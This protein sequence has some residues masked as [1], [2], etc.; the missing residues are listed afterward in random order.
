MSS[1]T[2]CRPLRSRR[3]KGNILVLSALLLVLM[4]AMAAFAVDLGYLCIARGELQRSADAAA[5]AACW[6][7]VNTGGPSGYS[8]YTALSD[9]A[10]A[11]AAQYATLNPI[12]SQGPA[13][14]S[15]DVEVGYIADPRDP[16]SPFL[17]N[18]ALP[19]NAVH[20]R[21]L[22]TADQ[23]GQLPL[24]FGRVLGIDKVN[25]QAD[26]TAAVMN[27]FSGFQAP[28]DGT[29]L[30]LLPFALDQETWDGLMNGVGT[31]NYSYNSATGEV[32]SGSDGILEV[33]LYPQ[34]TG[35]PG[36]RGTVDFGSSNNSTADISRQITSGVNASDMA[37]MG[38][39]VE[40]DSTGKLY[41]N[42]DTGISAGV[43][44]DLAS[45]KGLARIIPV[46]SSVSGPGNNATY[47]IVK[48]V[49]VRVTHVKLT[50]SMSSK[51]VIIQP[52]I[53]KTKGGIPSPGGTTSTF[54]YS[55]V[56]IVR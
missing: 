7:L 50:G 3:R 56:W 25:G 22:K 14:G 46:F 9:S 54:V 52:A 28:S 42:G 44:D 36:N 32:T 15:S 45:I 27:S 10:R 17:T 39:K 6:D 23:N 13:L 48:F 55:P 12:M 16:N 4:M 2:H 41:L 49:G 24:F 53:C 31:D 30:D 29:N 33:N 19:P 20:V 8:N 43:K 40:F 51:Q 11:T 34:G 37:H 38:G 47:T 1:R 18:S 5:D 35:A 26:A 21:V